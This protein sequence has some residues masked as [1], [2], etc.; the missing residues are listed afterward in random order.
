MNNGAD[1]IKAA[2]NA[3]ANVR[4]MNIDP[5]TGRVL[6]RDNKS[7][8]E[9]A[10]Q[11]ANQE[12]PV[13]VKKIVEDRKEVL[14]KRE[15]PVKDTVAAYYAMMNGG[16]KEEVLV[17]A[18]KPVEHQNTSYPSAPAPVQ[19]LKNEDEYMAALVAQIKKRR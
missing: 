2:M 15:K 7:I 13:E 9:D 5:E 12:I 3:M 1:T 17:E 8:L 18:N 4:K 10:Y 16:D 11:K 6:S 14:S 19:K